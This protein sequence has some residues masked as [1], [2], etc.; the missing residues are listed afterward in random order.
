MTCWEYESVWQA[1]VNPSICFRNEGISKVFLLRFTLWRY[2]G[3]F[4]LFGMEWGLAMNARVSS[5]AMSS[6]PQIQVLLAQVTKA[7]TSECLISILRHS[8]AP[9]S[10]RLPK[11]NFC[12][13]SQSIK[14]KWSFPS[15]FPPF[16]SHSPPSF[17]FSIL[18][19]NVTKICWYISAKV[20][21]INKTYS[22]FKRNTRSNW[23]DRR[24]NQ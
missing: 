15:F 4:I 22:L 11:Y 6:M 3:C 8:G 10:L 21:E 7:Q 19:Y 17:F 5:H 23:W 20:F 13:F 16:L 2:E 18:F 12:D 9:W 24:L 1:E 14:I